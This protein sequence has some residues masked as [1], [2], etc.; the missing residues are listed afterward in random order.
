MRYTIP[1]Y[2][3]S[4]SSL[5]RCEEEALHG[6]VLPENH[7]CYTALRRRGATLYRPTRKAPLLYSAAKKRRYVVTS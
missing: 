3:K 6:A 7:L 2:Q 1:S 4:T 5:Q